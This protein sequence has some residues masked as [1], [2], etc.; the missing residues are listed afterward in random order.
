VRDRHPHIR[1]RDPQGRRYHA[2]DPDT[3]YWAHA[4]FFEA[5]IATQELFGSP[6]SRAEKELLY[7]ESITWYERYGLSMRPVPRDYAAFEHYWSSMF[8]GVLEATPIAVA[9]VHR[10]RNLPAP[11]PAVDGL[12][13]SAVGP[14]LSVGGPWLT[15]GTLPAQAREILDVGWSRGDELT[16]RGLRSLLALAWPVVPQRFR[17]LPRARR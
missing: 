5:Q 13:W 15:R 6:L 9:A 10:T 8:E 14:L 12:L 1:G 16:L 3:Y 4:T 2:L 11:H 17:R 7:A